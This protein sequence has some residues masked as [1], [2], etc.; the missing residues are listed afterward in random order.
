MFLW[1]RG[2]KH[3][4]ILCI[5]LIILRLRNSFF[6][7]IDNQNS[8]FLSLDEENRIKYLMKSNDYNTLSNFGFFLIKL[9]NIFKESNPQI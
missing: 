2:Q 3:Y 5:N 8:N 4:L 7:N 9:E 1:Y 6:T